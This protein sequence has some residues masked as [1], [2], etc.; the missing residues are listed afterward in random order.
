M[1]QSNLKQARQKKRQKDNITFVLTIVFAVLAIGTAI[2]AFVVVRNLVKGW[3]MTDLPGAPQISAE[4]QPAVALSTPSGEG[5]QVPLDNSEVPADEWD[6]ASRVTVLIMGLDMRDWEAGEVPRSDTMIL[7]TMDPVKKT[8]GML[9]IPRDMWVNIPGYG[10]AKINQAYYFGELN[11]LPG[12]GPGLAV[13]TVE[14]FLG[15][16]IN[17]Y[18]QVDFYAFVK[19]IDELGGLDINVEQDITIGRIGEPGQIF[20]KPGVQTLDG[21]EVLGY[22]R[23]RYTEGDD[24]SRARRQQQV[25]MAIREQILTFNMLPTLIAKAPALY[26]DLSS[27]IRTN[28]NL[29]QVAQLAITA[30]QIQEQNIRRAVITPDMVYMDTSPDGLSILVPIPDEIRML[31]DQI[32]TSEGA[33]IIPTSVPSSDNKELMKAEAARVS[34][35]NGTT[36]EGLASR[37]AEWLR[38]EGVNIVEE[39]NADN[40]YGAT[41]IVVVNGKPYTVRWL[42]ETM[43]V[44]SSNIINRFDPNYGA[45][46]IVIVG[47]DWATNNSMP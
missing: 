7:F 40:V 43:G 14:Q 37:T 5:A 4:G 31:R 30:S 25:I 46:V 11:R 6:G 33:A 44:S 9:S 39:T 15:V 38:G 19:F 32:F 45:D 21:K 29:Q 34:I 47:N 23:A 8:A 3:T 28:L 24:F 10:Y 22:A 27:G 26:Q 35:Q 17:Y 12:G 16:P 13:Q 1:E 42:A 2:T 18:A 41:T 20:L 36:T